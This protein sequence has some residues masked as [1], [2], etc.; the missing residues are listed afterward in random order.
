MGNEKLQVTMEKNE[1]DGNSKSTSKENLRAIK[2][3]PNEQGSNAPLNA[4]SQ[5][6]AVQEDS[7]SEL[8]KLLK[9]FR[10]EFCGAIFSNEKQYDEH[11]IK[12]HPETTI[13]EEK[14]TIS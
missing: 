6:N 5:K 7:K 2:Q 11:V 4:S 3:E 12:L 13:T 14:N 8:V 10:C 9:P 1:E